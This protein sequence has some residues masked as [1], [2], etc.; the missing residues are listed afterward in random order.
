M[1]GS[2]SSSWPRGSRAALSCC[3]GSVGRVRCR[4]VKAL[5]TDWRHGFYQHN[6][7]ANVY[8]AFELQRRWASSVSARSKLCRAQLPQMLQ[9][10]R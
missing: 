1:N 6:K 4:D 2:N 3:S 8:T 10:L 7:L 9:L 5:F